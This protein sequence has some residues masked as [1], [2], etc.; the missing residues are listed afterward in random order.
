MKTHISLPASLAR[1]R[2]VQSAVGAVALVMATGLFTA[3]APDKPQFQSI[4]LTGADYAQGFSLADYNGQVRTLKDFSGKVVVVFFGFTQCPDVC[5]TSLADLAQT[6]KLLGSDGD[7]LQAIFITVD[8]ERDTPAVM[9]DY[10]AGFDAGI[11]PLSGSMAAVAEAAKAYRVYY[12]KHPSKDGGYDMDH[13]S[14]IYLM[15]RQG[16]FLANFTHETPPEQIAAKLR[17]LV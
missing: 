6:K 10:V 1:R 11:V 2:A 12:A 16:R 3:C 13:S 7:K 9:K 17:S 15:D 8:P 14:I 5:P 4:D